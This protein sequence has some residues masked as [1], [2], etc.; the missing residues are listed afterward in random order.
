[1]KLAALANHLYNC[2]EIGLHFKAL[3]DKILAFRA[4]SSGPGFE[5]ENNL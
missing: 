2:D 5:V 3:P 1:M 4:E